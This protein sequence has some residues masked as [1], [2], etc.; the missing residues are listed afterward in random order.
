MP[1]SQYYQIN[2]IVELIVRLKPAS[3]LEIG[4]GFGKYGFLCREYLEL[5]DGREAYGDWQCRIDCIE[6]FEKYITPAHRYL[7]NKIYTGD[8][9]NVL[10][11]IADHYDLVLIVDVLEHFSYGDGRRLLSACKEKAG[12]L[13]IASPRSV[14]AQHEVFENPYEQHRFE[15]KREHLREFG[16]AFFAP[17]HSTLICL[18]GEDAGRIGNAFR[19]QHLRWSMKKHFPF[20]RFLKK[21]FN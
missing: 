5:W 15:W 1:S 14:N 6:A 16:P 9:L 18:I 20:L 19:R 4:P 2:E 21:L 12:H 3:V 8:A 10:P 17:H 13:L 11:G 7:Y